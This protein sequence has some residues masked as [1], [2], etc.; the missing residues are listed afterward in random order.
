[1]PGWP[2]LAAWT[3]S[4]DRVRIVLMQ[5]VSRS[6]VPLIE[7][8]PGTRRATAAGLDVR[9]RPIVTDFREIARQSPRPDPG[10]SAIAFRDTTPSAGTL[11]TIGPGGMPGRSRP[12]WS[13]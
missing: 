4:I 10:E 7:A 13:T 3:A 12:T 2:E 6:A 5:R 9:D 8:S 1:M 11:R